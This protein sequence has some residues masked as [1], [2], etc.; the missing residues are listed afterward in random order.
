MN[1]APVIRPRSTPQGRSAAPNARSVLP[2]RDACARATKPPSTR[3]EDNRRPLRR[4]A[5]SILIT[6]AIVTTVG[7][8]NAFIRWDWCA[9]TPDTFWYLTVARDIAETSVLPPR[10]LTAPPGFPLVLAPWI[11]AEP[12]SAIPLRILF[13]AC[14]TLTALLTWRLHRRE[15]GEWLA[16]AAALLV[17]LSSVMMSCFTTILSEALF[18]PAFLL[19]LILAARW[20]RVPVTVWWAAAGGGLLTAVPVLIRAAGMIVMP[21]MFLTVLGVCSTRPG[22]E[23]AGSATMESGRRRRARESQRPAQHGNRLAR[24][25]GLAGSF[26]AASGLVLGAWQLRQA[27]FT[28]DKTYAAVWTQPRAGEIPANALTL[29]L[30]RLAEYGPTRLANIK[31]AIAPQTIGWRLFQPPLDRPTSWMIGGLV[32]ALALFRFARGRHPADAAVLLM[33]AMLAV[34]PFDEGA[35]LVAPLVP[36]FVAYPLWIA[37]RIWDRTPGASNRMMWHRRPAGENT[38]SGACPQ[39]IVLLALSRARV[40]RPLLVGGVLLLLSIYAAEAT[41]AVRHAATRREKSHDRRARMERMG[42]WMN[43]NIAPQA[44]C[45]A[46]VPDGSNDKLIVL[47]GA[48]LAR[49]KLEIEDVARGQR[50]ARLP[51][52][53]DDS[54]LLIHQDLAEPATGHPHHAPRDVIEGFVVIRP[55]PPTLSRS[56]PPQPRSG[57]GRS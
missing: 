31:Q 9:V 55:A 25:I 53:S 43:T 8:L 41:Y 23:S 20:R 56:A 38:G 37:K 47:G 51:T 48:Y 14:W 35:R 29:Q 17:A 6:I 3:H 22:A 46:L 30:R 4:A 10:H 15:L 18:L 5:P 42:R 57:P 45:R 19:C 7:A 28:P 34:W 27:Q 16:G 44:S 32:V 11:G 50:P 1:P 2:A 21:V 36:V 52:G 26:L 24:R 33:L 54:I 13:T 39:F 49:R 12:L 40:I